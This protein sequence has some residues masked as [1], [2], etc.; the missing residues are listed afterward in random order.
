MALTPW[1]SSAALVM[2]GCELG[3]GSVIGDYAVIGHPASS[4]FRDLAMTRSAV[5]ASIVEQLAAEGF[6]AAVCLGEKSQIR[7][8]S[9]I[10]ER[11][12]AGANLD[13]S[14]FVVVR[15]DCLLGSDC[16]LKVGADLRRGVVVGDGSTIAGLVGDRSVI[17]SGSAAAAPHSPVAEA[18]VAG[19]RDPEHD[20]VSALGV[21]K[22]TLLGFDRLT[23][24]PVG[25]DR[26]A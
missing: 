25:G 9:V 15:E 11:V 13:V 12:S 16:Y 8:F 14:H 18:A 5:P 6:R 7:S 26:E 2:P 21:D 1:V 3:S 20:L 24:P 19:G 22:S 4:S 23:R 10:Y 17:G